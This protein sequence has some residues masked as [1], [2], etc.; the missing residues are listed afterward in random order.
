MRYE[1]VGESGVGARRMRVSVDRSALRGWSSNL[2]ASPHLGPKHRSAYE[3]SWPLGEGTVTSFRSQRRH[4]SRSA[5]VP[6][7]RETVSCF[8]KAMAA[9]FPA[10]LP[11]SSCDRTKPPSRAFASTARRKSLEERGIQFSLGAG[12]WATEAREPA[13][14]KAAS[15]DLSARRT[16]LT[17]R[18]GRV[19]VGRDVKL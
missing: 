4:A 16:K 12:I 8:T 14:A 17:G 1:S 13:P 5:S 7:S 19:L 18:D 6:S 11:P 2:G 9:R 3:T 15:P 10:V